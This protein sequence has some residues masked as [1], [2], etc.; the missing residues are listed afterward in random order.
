MKW[1]FSFLCQ[2]RL[3]V[4]VSVCGGSVIEKCCLYISS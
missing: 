4:S 3:N 2:T 1:S